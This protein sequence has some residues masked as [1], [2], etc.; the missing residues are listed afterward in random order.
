M[1]KPLLLI[2]GLLLLLAVEILKVYF[3]MP[4]PGSQYKNTIAVAYFID[5][6][7]W[8]L[9][10]L[11]VILV[12]SPL[13]YYVSKGKWWQKSIVLIVLVLYGIIVYAFNFK[14][15]A[16]KMFY[17]PKIKLFAVGNADTTNKNKLVIG[18]AIN[19]EAKAYPIELIGYHHQVK[20]TVGGKPVMVT[21][22]TVCRTGR[23]Y[24][25]FVNGKYELF[26]LVGMDHFNAMFEDATTHSWWQ[27]ATGTAITGKLKGTQ[28]PEIPSRQMR[29]GDWLALYPNSAVLQAD[30]TY[31][32]EYDDLAGYDDGIL[33][34]KLE[35]RD[36]AS[37]K[38]KSWV[39]GVS[40]Y[41]QSK[42]YDWNELVSK[43]LIEDTLGNV[44][45]A[46][47]LEPNGKTFYAL[48]RNLNGETLHLTCDTV[49]AVL[50]DAETHSTWA[51][52]GT[53]TDGVAK[54]YSLK[55]VQAYQEFWHSW[56]TFHPATQQYGE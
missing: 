11:G 21:Y 18:V 50:M 1:R 13:V 42:A 38:F 25:P 24:S 28:L 16:D 48:N 22:C 47:V 54:G 43:K 29:L 41:G 6:Y 14:F 34:S 26:R 2:I 30:S 53:S 46:L 35:K 52:S 27:Q 3:I 4:F 37:W 12:F 51:L 55:P 39:V 36:S 8:L 19:G 5:R 9:R 20:D 40:I 45:I 10:L 15:L 23:V 32:T 33:K 44:P 17:Q 56:R 31:K 49:K 7:V